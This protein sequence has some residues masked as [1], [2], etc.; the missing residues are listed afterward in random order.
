MRDRRALVEVVRVHAREVPSTVVVSPG[1]RGHASSAERRRDVLRAAAVP[2]GSAPRCHRH[3]PPAP[4]A[5]RAAGRI[6][7]RLRLRPPCAAPAV[8][9]VLVLAAPGT[10][11]ARDFPKGSS[12][13]RPSPASR[14]RRAAAGE[15]GQAQRLV[16]L[17]PRPDQHRRGHVSG[18]RVERGPGHWRLFRR[19]AALARTGSA[20]TPSASRSSGAG[21]SRARR[22]GARTPRQLDRL[23]EP[24]GGPPLRGRAARDPPQRDDAD[25]HAQP[26]H[27]ADLA[28]R[29]DRRPRRL[30]RRRPRRSAAGGRARRLAGRQRTVPSSAGSRPGRR[31]ARRPVDLWVTIN[32][33]MVVAVNGYVNVAGAFAGWFPPGVYSF[34]AAVR[35]VRNLAKANAL[36]YDAVHAQRPPRARGS[37]AEHDR[38]HARRSRQRGRPPGSRARRLRLQPPVPQRRRQGARRPR[39]GRPHRG[40]RA[41]CRPARSRRL[42]RRQ[43]LLPQ[44]RDRPAR[45]GQLHRRAVRLPAHQHLPPP[46]EPDRPALPDHLHRIRGGGLPAGVPRA[47]CARPA[48]TACRST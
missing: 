43:L 47:C 21:S 24:G 16:G 7:G 12:G 19:D 40:R 9:L 33:P 32:E 6:G 11:A 27:A 41:A 18:D 8:S 42:H 45:P 14:P 23:V 34:P 2:K 17:E 35:V 4:G 5:E 36:A 26:L 28:A 48:A 38:L 22:D 44:P 13:A 46:A 31:G 3:R 37:G 25:G 10:A 39:R 29:P 20:R 15:R 1:G 30:R